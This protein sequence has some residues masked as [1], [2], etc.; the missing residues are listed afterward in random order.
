MVYYGIMLNVSSFA[1]DVFTNNFLSGLV[2]IPCYLVVV[3]LLHYSR[4]NSLSVMLLC[5]SLALLLV[6]WVPENG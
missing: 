2:E 4:K 6:P 3:P 5:A 1:G